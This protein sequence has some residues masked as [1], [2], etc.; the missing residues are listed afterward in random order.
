MA[1]HFIG[2]IR[3]SRR[4]LSRAMVAGTAIA[5]LGP[6]GRLLPTASGAPQSRKRF[7]VVNCYGGN[8]TLNMFVPVTLT[9]YFSRRTGLALQQNQL[10]ALNGPNATTKY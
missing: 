5:A 9:P 6:L 7:V 8:D 1:Q 3:L 4:G 10:L 2:D